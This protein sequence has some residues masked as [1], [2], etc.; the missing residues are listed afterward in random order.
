MELNLAQAIRQGLEEEME[1]NDRVI[2]IG[3][4]VAAAGGIMG[5]T[6]GLLDK[7][8]SKRVIDSPISEIALA[9]FGVGA[10]MMGLRP[11]VEIMYMDFTPLALEQVMNQ[12]AQIKFVSAGKLFAPF[13]IRTQYSLGRHNGPQHSQFFPSTFANIVGINVALPSR[14]K[15]AK[16]LI[17]QALR[18]ER[19]TVFIEP[20]YHYF[21][22]TEEVPDDDYVTPFGKGEVIREG[23]DLT[24]VVLSRLV[25]EALSAAE[26]LEKKGISAEVID[27]VT[28]RP[29]DVKTIAASVQKTGRLLIASDEHENSSVASEIA[30]DVYELCYGSLKK[31]VLRLHPPEVHVPTSPALES[32]YMIDEDKLLRAAESLI[33]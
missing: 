15:V 8:G 3:E 6:K 19:P 17:K 18:D 26:D 12:G 23:K 4:D 33:R 31:P 28:A 32:Q 13:V 29:L 7:F 27:P 11:V 24:I 14:P 10:A 30:A 5:V 1:R 20:S 22:Y 9:G 2:I 25:P 16:G 21:D